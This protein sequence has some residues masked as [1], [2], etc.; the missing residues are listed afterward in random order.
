MLGGNSQALV[1]QSWEDCAVGLKAEADPEEANRLRWFADHI[2][3][4]DGHPM[5]SWKGIWVEHLQFVI[6]PLVF[7]FLLKII[8]QK[9]FMYFSHL[10]SF[11]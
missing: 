1:P 6:N 7:L 9:F 2:L 11:K 10:I 4:T 8:F 5:L 3:I